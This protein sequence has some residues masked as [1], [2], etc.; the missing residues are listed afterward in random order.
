MYW[1]KFKVELSSKFTYES[2][3]LDI[4]ML[5]F[6]S[7]L[8]SQIPPCSILLSP[9]SKLFCLWLGNFLHDPVFHTPVVLH[10]NVISTFSSKKKGHCVDPTCNGR[11]TCQA[12]VCICDIGWMGPN[13][14]RRNEALYQCLPDCTGHGIFNADLGKCECHSKWT[15]REC[16]ISKLSK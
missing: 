4:Y 6:R 11:G 8:H 5:L 7:N 13:C 16:N 10:T 1:G 3:N 14:E 12:A 2:P 9:Y 15:G